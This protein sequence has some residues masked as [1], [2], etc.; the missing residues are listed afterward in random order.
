VLHRTT[1]RDGYRADTFEALGREPDSAR[2]TSL[3]RPIA[4]AL[5]RIEQQKGFAP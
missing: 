3:V 5:A 2:F 4:T 1:R